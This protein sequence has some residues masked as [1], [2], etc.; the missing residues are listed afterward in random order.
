M[1]AL[2]ALLLCLPL[3]A[4]GPRVPGRRPVF[5]ST[6]SLG[7]DAP[8]L[9]LRSLTLPAD[10]VGGDPDFLAFREEGLTDGLPTPAQLEAVWSAEGWDPASPRAVLV[11][12]ANRPL[13]SWPS[14]PSPREVLGALRN[15]GWRPRLE[16]LEAFIRE[17][18]DQGQARAA[19]LSALLG[20]LLRLVETRDAELSKATAAAAW[21]ALRDLRAD[22][23]WIDHAP[24]LSWCGLLNQLAKRPNPP[25]TEEDLRPLREELARALLR[26]TYD[27]AM[28]FAWSDLASHPE[29]VQALMDQLV[30]LPG[31]PP[32]PSGAVMPV[33]MALARL[34][35]GAELETLA[36]RM[37]AARPAFPPQVQSRW[38]G[39]RV[40]AL[41]L[42]GRQAEGF[43]QLQSDLEQ[44][45]GVG[46][47][48]LSF[49]GLPGVTSPLSEAERKQ[50][51]DLLKARGPR[52][53][54]P[55]PPEAPPL[56]RLDLAGTPAWAKAAAALPAHPAFD[57]WA[58]SELTWGTLDPA[59]WA[60]LRARQGWGPEGRWVLHRGD[61]LLASGT[62]LPP[63]GVLADRLREAD[64]SQLARLRTLL[65]QHPDLTAARRRRLRLLQSRMPHPRLELLLMEDALS[66]QEPFLFPVD[67]AEKLQKPLWESAARRIL[68]VLEAQLRR[69]P[70]DA[71]AWTAWLD[72][73]RMAGN[74]DAA[75]LLG[76]LD[77]PP[78]DPVEEGPL[79]YALATELSEHLKAQERLTELAAWG[80]PFWPHLLAQLP[81]A[82]EA[83]K[84]AT[85]Q[86][87]EGREAQA[88]WEAAREASHRVQSA[89]SL[90]RP[91]VGALR[92]TGAAAEAEAVAQALEALQPGLS[93]RLLG[94][95]ERKPP[96]APSRPAPP[97]P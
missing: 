49:T 96:T 12:G 83:A 13:A 55:V 29:E 6:L 52:R 45:P 26:N 79:P 32:L 4:Q 10:W 14:L 78:T 56:L 43:R 68:P 25:F 20:R 16:R 42:Q 30:P 67:L 88:R 24:V 22:P 81:V 76:R 1:R 74:G 11:D 92:A 72:W 70:E 18:P 71:E 58:E 9:W 35:A 44:Q 38:L 91:W 61:D 33:I 57:D 94:S 80:R 21:E 75:A 40:A 63:A 97:R 87:P 82:L 62:E 66:L 69:W 7:A 28:W 60:E 73:T 95:P 41:L 50:V 90:L 37:L 85:R 53:E 15:S 47:W 27:S 2:P 31:E 8:R 36:E 59:A 23:A 17:H 19:R 89:Q 84:G 54:R 64:P 65:K 77:L 93:L 5:L 3:L 39:A 34:G 51:M 48:L 86:P 46:F